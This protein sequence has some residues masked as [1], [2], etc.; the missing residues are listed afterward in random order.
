MQT[1]D[2]YDQVPYGGHAIPD[3]HP[4]YL[5]TLAGMLGIA[6]A[7]PQRCRVLELG[8]AAGDNL[9]PMAF[10]LP[11]SDFVGVELGAH[12]AQRG[13]ALIA[14]LGLTNVV[15]LHQD[16]LSL[17]ETLGRFDYILAHGVYSW[18]PDPVKE[19]ILSL[20]G[21]LLTP[22]GVAYVSYNVLPGWHQ[23]GMLRGMLLHQTSGAAT[24][25]ERLDLA[26]GFLELL[27]AGMD[28]DQRP[29]VQSLREELEYL[30][31]ARPAYLYHEY[32]EATN[33]PETF[34]TFLGRAERHGLRYLADTQLHT[35]FASTLA[36][37]A[38]A[39]VGL[40][41]DQTEQ[42]QLM[43]FLTLRP[44][45]RSL[46]IRSGLEP[47][48]EI[49]L[50]HLHAYGLYADLT[51]T[52]GADL[53]RPLPEPYAST[54]G[55][56]FVVEHPLTKAVLQ[57]LATA[58]PNALPLAALLDAARTLVEDAGGAGYATEIDACQ[59][60][61]FSLYASQGLGLTLNPATWSGHLS[62]RP[63]AS[64]LARARAA[65]GETQVA[66]ARHRNLDLDR[67][68]ALLLSLLDGR[69]DRAALEA[70][71]FGA[72]QADPGFQET[73]AQGPSTPAGL[74]GQIKANC[75]RLLWVFARN[76]LLEA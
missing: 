54:A 18:V 41:K 56:D 26:Y 4:D 11:D 43:D 53:S 23:R 50:Q 14:A 40:C 33:A 29:L 28:Q 19:Q 61:P 55:D 10:Q 63:R 15:L 65:A 71:L 36:P 30:R 39:V 1:L 21:R 74:Q 22:N 46:L 17:D 24:P 20:C 49:D 8:A 13:Q 3:T 45:R 27:A 62:E 44:F 25:A 47:N 69:H 5:A 60:E 59:G 72:L 67:V 9:I 35:M 32:L 64:A 51:P 48:L 68:S 12:Q 31:E 42:E 58:Y 70:A 38:Q 73:L 57:Q 75:E 52:D 7:P 76:G 66:T 37:A 16:I 34:S 2:S 6:A